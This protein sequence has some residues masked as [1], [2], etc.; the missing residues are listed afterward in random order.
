MAFISE[1]KIKKDRQELRA[2][3]QRIIEE[4]SCIINSLS[5]GN[6]SKEELL[7]ASKNSPF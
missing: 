2:A 4:V 1:N 3:R 5:V 6:L 7:K